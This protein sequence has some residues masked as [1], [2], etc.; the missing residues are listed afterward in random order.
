MLL[1]VINK[2]TTK[3]VLSSSL[4]PVGPQKTVVFELTINELEKS[5]ADLVRLAQ[6]GIIS[7]STSKT[8]STSDDQAE[9]ATVS[10]VDISGGGGGGVPPS[11]LFSAGAGLTGGGDLSA[12]RVFNV[13]AN[14]DGSMVVNAN[15]IQVGVLATDGQHGSRGGGTLHAAVVSGGASGFMTG[16]QSTKLDG[17]EA[18][19]DVTDAT[20]VAAAGAIMDSDFSGSD[21][22]VLRR[23]GA[24]TYSRLKDNLSATVAPTTNDDSGDGYAVG[25][26]WVDVTG[27]NI[28]FCI[29]ATVAS[30]VWRLVPIGGGGG[31]GDVVGPV[32]A[33]DEAVALF[34][35]ITGKIIQNSLVTIS[36]TGSI[37]LVAG[38]TVDGRDVSVDGSTLDTHVANT[39]NPHSVTAAQVGSPPNARAITAGAGMTGGGDLS[40]DRTLDV[41]ANADG[42][43]VVNAN[44]IQVGVLATDAQHGVRGGGT[45]HAAVVSGGASGF[46]TGA[47]STKL[48]G[49]EAAADVTDATNV[50]AA[51]A[52]MDSDFS[53]SDAGVLRRTGAG[54]YS[55]LK[56]N[57]AATAAPTANDDSGDGYAVGSMWCDTTNDHVY[58]CIDATLTSAV[59]RQVPTGGASS[60]DNESIT[61]GSFTSAGGSLLAT[62]VVA[63]VDSSG[64]TVDIALPALGAFSGDRVFVVHKRSTDTNTIRLTSENVNGA[65]PPFV[66]PGSTG[67]HA[68]WFVRR[69]AAG[70][71]YCSPGAVDNPVLI[72]G[73]STT[74]D[75]LAYSGGV[76]ARLPIGTAGQVLTVSG[77]SP[78][79][80]TAS[81]GGASIPAI[82]GMTSATYLDDARY[83]SLGSDPLAIANGTLAVL[84]NPTLGAEQYDNRYFC[85]T[86]NNTGTAGGGV[87]FYTTSAFNPISRGFDL[88]TDLGNARQI[89]WTDRALVS[90]WTFMVLTWSHS[91]GTITVRFYVNGTPVN[92]GTVLGATVGAGG[93]LCLGTSAEAAVTGGDGANEGWFNGM[94]Y[95]TRSLPYEQV[96]ELTDAVFQANQLVDIPTG[97]SW[98]GAWRVGSGEPGSSWAASFGTGTLTRTGTA[99]GF[100]NKYAIWG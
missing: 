13:G 45:Q 67:A 33:T 29:D 3:I 95:A 47:Q 34:D 7:W 75:L 98:T 27:D 83:W 10:Y 81:G 68:T 54:A 79:W 71:W 56:D 8:A 22:G 52:I 94:G 4:G 60:P 50:A 92:E 64:G 11:R 72:P 16:A 90:K 51:G 31:S 65:A 40:A 74:G 2:T 43:I 69:N 58:F 35:G 76:Y 100:A 37:S 5:R 39:S 70:T 36:P 93:N 46:M 96:A 87:C 78:V 57:L 82:G 77:G 41:V 21:A 59:W 1:T 73:G 88:V 6:S 91:G 30:A 38:Q 48:D 25:S 49:I 24:G 61:I 86:R 62:H 19:A 55:L 20:N 84:C 53:G 63:D 85:G 18:G 9:G 28:Y 15:D 17:I 99:A 80:A 12:D 44:D 14:A 32:S 42:S 26:M 97:G 23:T 89:M 66:L